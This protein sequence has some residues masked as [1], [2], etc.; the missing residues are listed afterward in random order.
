MKTVVIPVG[1]GA[2]DTCKEWDGGKHKESIRSSYCDGDSK[3][4]QAGICA[5]PQKAA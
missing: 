3:D 4:L 5:N 1:V 2:L